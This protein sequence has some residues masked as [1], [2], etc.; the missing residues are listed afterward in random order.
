MKEENAISNS[1]CQFTDHEV[2]SKLKRKRLLGIFI[3]RLVFHFTQK[4]NILQYVFVTDAFLYEMNMKYLQHDTYTDI[5]TFDLSEKKSDTIDGEI[6]ISIDR[7]KENA[8]HEDVKYMHELYRVILHGALHLCGFNDKTKP[9]KEIMR[10]LE[11][12]WL[13]KYLTLQKEM[14]KIN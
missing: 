1:S 11:T 13:E 7:V 10:N 4:E 2:V 8:L 3:N 12:E 14:R 9:Q 5:I 6:Y